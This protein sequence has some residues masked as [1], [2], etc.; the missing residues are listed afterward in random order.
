LFPLDRKLPAAD[1]YPAAAAEKPPERRSSA[2]RLCQKYNSK[3]RHGPI[4]PAE[5]QA[6]DLT[7]A[8]DYGRSRARNSGL[9]R[10]VLFSLEA[11]P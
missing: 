8:A 1:Q 11:Y 5:L 9:F 6:P 7:A 3:L 2:G 4:R 10:D